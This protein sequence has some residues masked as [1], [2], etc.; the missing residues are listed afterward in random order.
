[1]TRLANALLLGGL[2]VVAALLL[3]LLAVVVET[4]IAANERAA[5]ER[6]MLEVV[7]GARDGL[8]LDAQPVPAA[9][10]ALLGLT[11]DDGDLYLVRRDATLIGVIAPVIA[12]GYGGPISAVVGIDLQGVV[13]GVRVL[14]HRETPG[15]GDDID[16]GKS[17]WILGFNG[18]SLSAPSEAAW[19][20]KKDGGHFDGMTGA[21]VTPRAV[22]RQV[23]SAL[24]Y[25]AED[26][27][28]RLAAPPEPGDEASGTSDD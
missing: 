11:A 19:R 28:R 14:A 3:T 18:T 8:A 21:T 10:R 22:V 9:Y 5:R 1:M 20:V 23:Q 2:A 6:T 15:L 12:Q 7:P 13:T 4:R 25:F 16:L 24:R 27:R 26:G 17:N